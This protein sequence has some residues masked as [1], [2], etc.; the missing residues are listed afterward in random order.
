MRLN[1]GFAGRFSPVKFGHPGGHHIVPYIVGIPAI[2]YGS[3]RLIW[4]FQPLFNFFSQLNVGMII[5]N[6]WKIKHVPNLQPEG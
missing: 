4:W 2:S 1:Q 3:K 5:P 6:I